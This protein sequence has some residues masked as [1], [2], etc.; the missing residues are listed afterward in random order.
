MTAPSKATTLVVV[1]ERLSPV[2]PSPP[3][4][5]RRPRGGRPADSGS[6]LLGRSLAGLLVTAL[7]V[8]GVGVW[9]VTARLSG[10]VVAPGQLVV[11]GNVKKVQHPTGG[12]VAE[13]RVKNG[14]T[15]AARDVVMTLDDG[16]SRALAAIQVAKIVAL[17][18]ERARLVAERDDADDLVVPPRVDRADPAVAAAFEGERR[19]LAARRDG[20]TSQKARLA[21]RIVQTRREIEALGAQRQ[22]KGREIGL[23]ERELKVVEGLADRQLANL[24]R[25]T[26]LQREAARFAG[27]IGALDAQMAR[28]RSSVAEIELQ[29]I[30]FDQRIV[31]DVHRQI[32]EIDGQLA[33]VVERKAAA[34][35]QVRRTELRAPASGTVHELAQHTVG[36][37]VRP[38]ETIMSVVPQRDTL[39]VEVR[40][41]PRDIDQVTVGQ[42]ALLR[43]SALNREQTPEVPGT[44]SQV[45]ADVSRE[46]ATGREYFMARI[47]VDAKAAEQAGGADGGLQLTPGMPV[48]SFIET[49]SRTA[50]SYILKPLTDQFQRALRE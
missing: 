20:W 4:P 34:D 32:R 37:V 35:E 1:P 10:A 39:A 44:V 5:A 11:D 21:E 2:P 7:L 12:V 8:L 47:V 25:V 49:D 26:G 9:S 29:I 13:I 31:T 42:R 36:G 3:R 38:G 19:L 16:Q 33:E 27:E 50:L 46:A 24:N 23:I 40:I 17:E 43:F 48:D 41:A 18:S 6:G 45:G 14:D 30:E 28:A 22:A 15:V